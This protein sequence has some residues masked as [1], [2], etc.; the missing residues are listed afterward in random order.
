MTYRIGKTLKFEAAHSLPHLADGHKCRRIHGHNYEVEL[1]LASDQL[2]ADSF[3]VDFG[4]IS[5]TAGLW[6][7]ENWDH[8]YINGEEGHPD[9]PPSE[10]IVRPSTAEN[11][12]A[13]LYRLSQRF[14]WGV[15]L[16]SVTVWE[17]DDSWATYS[18]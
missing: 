1:T 17:T 7:K 5:A 3:V 14:G 4:V 2:D 16:E 12:A 18:E 6:I 13:H 10:G 9:S 15:L 11:M 8:R